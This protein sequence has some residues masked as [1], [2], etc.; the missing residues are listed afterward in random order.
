MSDPKWDPDSDPRR[1]ADKPKTQ[2][3][4][5]QKLTE[6]LGPQ[7]DAV[8]AYQFME[9]EWPKPPHKD[10]PSTVAD[11]AKNAVDAIN[12]LTAQLR[13]KMDQGKP[14]SY[15]HHTVGAVQ[16][17]THNK[18]ECKGRH[19]VIH[20]PSDHALRG[21]PRSWRTDIN[22]MERV[23]PHGVGHPDPDEVAYRYNQ[24][25]QKNAGTHGCDGCCA[26]AKEMHEVS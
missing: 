22:R 19:C 26:T 2:A 16:I 25:G 4:A 20:N 14:A 13:A 10:I 5:L 15:E 24:L 9:G 3:E 12:R 7:I 21:W 23:C 17:R 8:G 11:S 6:I 18:G 1:S